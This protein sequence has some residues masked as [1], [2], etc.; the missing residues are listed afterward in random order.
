MQTMLRRNQPRE[1]RGTCGRADRIAAQRMREAN[2]LCSQVID[3][4]CADVRIAIATERPR[5][6]IVSEDEDNI[7]R[8]CSSLKRQSTKQHGEEAKR[9]HVEGNGILR[10]NLPRRC[11]LGK[12]C[13]PNFVMKATYE[14]KSSTLFPE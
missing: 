4:R 13:C 7:D 3:V 10:V 2:S 14:I 5:T 1:E 11:W 6:L 12:K 9:L 8:L